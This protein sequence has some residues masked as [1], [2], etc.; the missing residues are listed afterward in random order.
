YQYLKNINA[1]VTILHG[2]EDEIIPFK[3]SIKLKKENPSI[4]L[5]SINKGKHNDLADYPQFWQ[6]ITKLLQ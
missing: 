1:P 2:T 3:Q 6:T 4:S 5:V